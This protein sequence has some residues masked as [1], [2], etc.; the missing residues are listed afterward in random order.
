MAVIGS[1]QSNGIE[2]MTAQLKCVWMLSFCS[3][4][5]NDK[6]SS[7]RNKKK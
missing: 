7:Y 1:E 5:M 3:T 4:T 6:T 2:D